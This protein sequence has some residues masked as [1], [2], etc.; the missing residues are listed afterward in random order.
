MLLS[1]ASKKQKINPSYCSKKL[2]LNQLNSLPKP[3]VTNDRS[4]RKKTK[5][6]K[7]SNKDNGRD[8]KDFV[9]NDID[10]N[11]VISSLRRQSLEGKEKGEENIEEKKQND[12]GENNRKLRSSLRHQSKK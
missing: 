9:N 10:F 11:R 6:R 3:V 8:S 5:S 12:N 1:N 7:K 4:P 2:S